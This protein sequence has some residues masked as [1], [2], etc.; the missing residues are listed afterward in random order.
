MVAAKFVIFRESHDE[1]TV[2]VVQA[3][4]PVEMSG[5]REFFLILKKALTVWRETTVSGAAAWKRSSED[6]NVGDLSEHQ[7][8]ENLKRI[9]KDFGIHFLDIT[10]EMQD[11]RRD[12]MWNFDTVLMDEE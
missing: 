6:F 9:L 5:E 10:V 12:G 3:N 7:G 1:K 8:D 2:A 4:V 11:H